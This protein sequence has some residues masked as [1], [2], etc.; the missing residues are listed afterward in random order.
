MANLFSSSGDFYVTDGTRNA[1]GQLNLFPATYLTDSNGNFIVDYAL[2]N[3]ALNGIYS[4]SRLT[5]YDENGNA[6]PNTNNYLV[7][8]SPDIMNYLADAGANNLLGAAQALL[9]LGPGMY[10]DQQYIGNSGFIP[11]TTDAGN[12][13]VGVYG[14]NAGWSLDYTL[15][16]F[17]QAN[18]YRGSDTSQI[19]GN[20]LH[21]L[22]EIVQGYMSASN[23]PNPPMS[24]ALSSTLNDIA[25]VYFAGGSLS[26]TRS[27][28]PTGTI[29]SD[30][31]PPS[32]M[33]SPSL[34][35][36]A[37]NLL[38]GPDLFANAQTVTPVGIGSDGSVII[39]PSDL[40]GYGDNANPFNPGG[41]LEQGG[42]QTAPS[43]G[44]GMGGYDPFTGGYPNASSETGASFADAIAGGMDRADA[45]PA[46]GVQVASADAGVAT[47]GSYS[48][49]TG[50]VSGNG[51]NPFNP[52]GELTDASY[53]S[54]NSDGANPNL[55]D[56]A[57]TNLSGNIGELGAPSTTPPVPVDAATA[58]QDAQTVQTTTA[59]IGTYNYVTIGGSD[60]GGAST[61]VIGGGGGGS[62]WGSGNPV[63][64]DLK[65]KGV[66]ITPLSS[67][68][69]FFDMANNG[70]EQ[71]TAWAGAGNGVLVYDPGGGPVTH[72]NQVNFTL[73]DPSAKTGMQA[74]EQVFDTNHDGV[75]NSSDADW[76]GIGAANVLRLPRRERRS[77]VA[78]SRHTLPRRAKLIPPEAA[79]NRR[80]AQ[81]RSRG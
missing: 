73:W 16:L 60:G 79:G 63:V 12:F 43:D 30:L 5:L 65:G 80:E 15:Q 42:N 48:G 23:N 3:G 75:L 45:S 51:S 39:N 4:A 1:D 53:G 41:A 29:L 40:S 81:C 6:F 46:G 69:M 47:D 9:V 55:Y 66:K 64:L 27:T 14:A 67:S 25:T 34:L 58:F 57:G 44:Y 37:G 78:K 52:G 61:G 77:G 72:A 31:I 26:D 13:G 74:L 49:G 20:S 76:D 22:I 38:N 24:E 50:L 11:A 33:F 17:G 19:Y 18:S 35:N 32:I 68:N 8:P 10:G 56:N 2:A 70:F 21:G 28:M 54:L 71:K 7:V 36:D 62:S 59:S